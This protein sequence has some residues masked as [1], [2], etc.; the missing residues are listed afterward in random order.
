MHLT[1]LPETASAVQRSGWQCTTAP[2]SAFILYR[3]RWN[4][5]SIEG[6]PSDRTFPS[7]ESFTMSSGVS[8]PLFLPDG[9]MR[10]SPSFSLTLM[11][12]PAETVSL[13]SYSILHV[14]ARRSRAYL[15]FIPS[16]CRSP[17]ASGCPSR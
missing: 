15:S 6:F 4:R 1:C 8:I 17:P 2:V 12:P 11:F 9:V 7:S 10:I 16:P 5:C 13:R 14:S 3:A